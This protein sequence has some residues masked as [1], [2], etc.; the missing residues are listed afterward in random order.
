MLGEQ[1]EVAGYALAGALV[2]TA[3]QPEQVR[4]AW[5]ELPGDVAVVVVTARAAAVIDAGAL[6]RTVPPYVVVMPP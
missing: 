4:A 6:R 5:S 3:E 1:A 2:M